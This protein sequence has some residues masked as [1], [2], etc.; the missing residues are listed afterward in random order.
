MSEQPCIFCEIIAGRAQASFVYSDEVCSAFL[1]IQ[2]V[3]VGHVLV[4]PN[5]HAAYL[6]DLEPE[7]GA[8]MFRVGQKVARALRTA[9]LRCEGVNMLLADGEAGNAGGFSWICTHS[10]VSRVM[11]SALNSRRVTLR[12]P[13]AVH[14]RTLRESF[15][16]R[17]TPNQELQR[18]NTFLASLGRVLAAEFHTLAVFQCLRSNNRPRDGRWVCPCCGPSL[19]RCLEVSTLRDYCLVGRRR[20]LAD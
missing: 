13:T 16:G 19:G 11:D 20:R 4:I 9:G 5:G 10:L 12:S 1:D 7:A 8:Q 14:S 6:S 2:P 3:N 15:A 17:F 18:T